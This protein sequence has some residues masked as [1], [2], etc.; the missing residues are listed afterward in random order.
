MHISEK[1]KN[2]LIIAKD[3][4]TKGT[5]KWVDLQIVHKCNLK[6]VMCES[7]KR[8]TDHPDLE[9]IKNIIRKIKDSNAERV[10]LWGGEPYLRTDIPEIFKF[11]KET[12]L[13]CKVTTNGT[14]F[15]EK[16]LSATVQYVD[17]IT[18]S[19]DGANS[20]T[21]E[22]IRGRQGCYN[23]TLT[24]LKKLYE[25][26]NMRGSKT[27]HI[28]I[29]CTVQ[30]LNIEGLE[31]ILELGKRFEAS[32]NFD[33]VQLNGIGNTK[34]ND[35]I[36]IDKEVIVKSFNNLIKNRKYYDVENSE[37]ILEL[38]KQY[39]LG[40]KIKTRCISPYIN[41]PMDI[42]GDVQFCWGWDNV[43]GNVFD[44]SIKEIWEKED[45]T[46]LRRSVKN[47]TLERCESCCFSHT[48]WPFKNEMLGKLL[49]GYRE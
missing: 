36:N 13:K 40:N 34:D 48:R 30:Q 17:N 38:C 27:P 12:G 28:E 23:K 19:I 18:F 4:L 25:L 41:M 10:N 46:A 11:I 42:N 29:D 15:T 5:P 37:H 45:N 7:W 39:M 20:Q 14:V 32:I 21:H 9:K 2:S 24:N 35:L 43:I 22:Q 49:F 44:N 16:T 6:C 1:I 8:Q 33:P 26:K 31:G 47:G 3:S